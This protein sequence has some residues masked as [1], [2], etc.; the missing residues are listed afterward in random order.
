MD[1]VL[2]VKKSLGKRDNLISKVRGITDISLRSC[3]AY[4]KSEPIGF[5]QLSM[6]QKLNSFGIS[7]RMFSR[8]IGKFFY[9]HFKHKAEISYGL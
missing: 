5:A 3:A 2:V 6:M 8:A 7:T 4:A 9:F 1:S